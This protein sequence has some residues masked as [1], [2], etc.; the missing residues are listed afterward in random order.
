MVC[1]SDLGI[2]VVNVEGVS[3]ER[4]DPKDETDVWVWRVE[5]VNV[6]YLD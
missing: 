4:I 2:E 6:E 5:V 1:V 3:V